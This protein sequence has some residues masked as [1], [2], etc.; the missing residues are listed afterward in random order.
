MRASCT[1]PPRTSPAVTNE[2][3]FSQY[4]FLQQEAGLTRATGSLVP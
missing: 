2:D 3:R 1:R 4:G